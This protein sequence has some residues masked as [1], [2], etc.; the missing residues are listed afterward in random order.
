MADSRVKKL[1]KLLVNCSSII[2]P[3]DKVVV[4]DSTEAL[5]LVTN[6]YA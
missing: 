2:Q 4:R 6:P 1:A 3:G 5:P